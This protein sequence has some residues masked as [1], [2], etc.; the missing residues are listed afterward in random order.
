MSSAH[1]REWLNVASGAALV[2]KGPAERVLRQLGDAVT[3]ILASGES[4]REVSVLRLVQEAGISRATFYR[5]FASKGEVLCALTD[6][7]LSELVVG[8]LPWCALAATAGRD[9]LR[10]ALHQL[11]DAYRRNA[12][13]ISAVQETA[14]FDAGVH[15]AYEAMISQV[16]QRISDHIIAG[17]AAAAISASIDPES[18]AQWLV[19]MLE[20]GA[21]QVIP[22]SDDT[23]LE[24]LEDAFTRIVWNALYRGARS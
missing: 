17:Q 23:G 14:P 22:G 9:D 8:T 3:R 6:S 5:H 2:P 7:S 10:A 24:S 19:R 13:L 21:Y 12:T 18:T 1:A 11:I 16:V 15:A 4:F 20:R